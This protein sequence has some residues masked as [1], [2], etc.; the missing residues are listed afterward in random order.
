MNGSV[1][2]FRARK[3][4]EASR[5]ARGAFGL[6]RKTRGRLRENCNAGR[7]EARRK[8]ASIGG[9]AASLREGGRRWL[10]GWQWRARAL[11]YMVVA[12]VQCSGGGLVTSL[13]G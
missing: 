7:P 3:G 11:S 10:D 12:T 5:H 6:R 9:M 8:G 2:L 1:V 13:V 4:H